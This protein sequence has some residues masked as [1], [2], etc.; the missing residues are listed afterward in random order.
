MVTIC[1][2]VLI[3]STLNT[4]TLVVKKISEYKTGHDCGSDCRI[5]LKAIQQNKT[6]T[7]FNTVDNFSRIVLNT[8]I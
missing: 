4:T 2:E 1:K 6:D 3:G 8:I 5:A 7:L